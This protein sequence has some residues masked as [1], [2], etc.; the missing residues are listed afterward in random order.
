MAKV[1]AILALST[2]TL[3]QLRQTKLPELDK[4]VK[5]NTD[6]LALLGY[7]SCELSLRRHDAILTLHK[8]YSSL[9]AL[10]VPVTSLLFGDNLQSRLNDIRASNKI[11]KTTF[12]ER[13]NQGKAGRFSNN[14]NAVSDNRQRRGENFLFRGRYWKQYPPKSFPQLKTNSQKRGNQGN[15]W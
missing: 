12:P 4:L 13:H 6:A 7:A 5:L 10:H 1:G 3:V 8:H 15:Q 11:S 9:C 2:E 14:N